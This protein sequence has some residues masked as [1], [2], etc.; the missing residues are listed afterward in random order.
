MKAFVFGGVTFLALSLVCLGHLG[1]LLEIGPKAWFLM[2]VAASAAL[3]YG[4]GGGLMLWHAHKER[5]EYLAS[6][7]RRRSDKSMTA[8]APL[9]LFSRWA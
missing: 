3:S 6:Q 1:M 8:P 5:Q 7:N 2:F 4:I 9:I